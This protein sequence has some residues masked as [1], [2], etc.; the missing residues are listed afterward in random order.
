MTAQAKKW[1]VGCGVMLSLA[2]APRMAS[3]DLEAD[4]KR[5]WVGAWVVV[6]VEVASDCA[7]FYTNNQ[8]R[9][10]LS[11]SKG[12]RRFAEGE[13]A[14]VDK[15][16]LR[17]ERVDLYLSLAA[18][19]LVARQDGPFTLLDERSCRVQLMVEI[20]P[21]LRKRG[22]WMQVDAELQEVV[23]R[24]ETAALARQSGGWNRRE[25]DPLPE[26]YEETLARHAV[27][28]A[29][30]TNR[31]VAHARQQALEQLAAVLERFA[32]DSDYLA[33][34]AAGVEAQRRRSPP[35]CA[36]LP[37]ARFEGDEQRPPR[38]RQADTAADR[39]FRRGFRDGQLLAWSARLARAADTCFVPVP[40]L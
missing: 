25:R 7:G 23:E 20:S 3:A 39:T 21:S 33:G 17:S 19:V 2:T 36:S 15:L 10:R 38:D 13:L 18:S 30:E 9:G 4:L 8:V 27:W 29:E 34:F 11:S 40:P 24:H 26:N 12:S 5:A 14:Q 32:E 6:R 31:G 16:N 35:P 1:L 22:D 37:H 28:K